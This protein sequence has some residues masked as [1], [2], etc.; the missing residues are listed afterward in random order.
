MAGMAGNGLKLFE[1]ARSWKKIAGKDWKKLVTAGNGWQ[2]AGYDQKWNG[3]ISVFGDLGL[4]DHGD[5]GIG[6]WGIDGFPIAI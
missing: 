4:G 2:F 3:S 1:M 5:W 6:D